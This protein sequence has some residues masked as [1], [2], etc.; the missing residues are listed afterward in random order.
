[1]NAVTS[2]SVVRIGALTCRSPVLCGS[3]EHVMTLAGVRAA[4][5][6]GVGGVVAKSI[7]ESEAAARQ[8]DR[9]DYV[10]LDAGLRPTDWASAAAGT[11]LFCRSGLGGHDPEEWF[12]ALAAIDREVAPRDQFVAGSIVLGGSEAAIGLCATAEAAGLRV[13]ELNMGAPHG[14]EAR[15]GSITIETDPDRAGA[16]VAGAR[17]AF[18]GQ[19]WIKLT[20]LGGDLVPLAAAARH[21]GADVVGL[22][23][24]FM[25]MVPDLDT[26]RPVLNTSAAYGGNWALPITC[27]WLALA[28]RALGPDAPLIG[29]NGARDGLDVARMLL[30]G[31]SAVQM[32]SAVMERGFDALG[33]A[34]TTLEDW[35]ATRDRTAAGIVGLAGDALETYGQQPERPDHWRAFAPAQTNG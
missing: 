24:R 32:S 33:E 5:G 1:M 9:A 16:I 12:G 4:L 22:M 2:R 10:R 25:G 18:K 27:R 7:N 20:G 31:A 19:L 3:G 28:R 17:A 11:S 21:A 23:G 29:T 15:P 13:L 14:S 34:V 35:L 6:Q 26:L 30:A 8:I